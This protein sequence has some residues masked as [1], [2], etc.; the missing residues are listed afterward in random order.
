MYTHACRPLICLE[1]GVGSGAVL[2]AV[3]KA[4]G[5]GTWCIGTDI[6]HH[7]VQAVHAC[8]DINQMTGCT[9]IILTDLMSAVHHRLKHSIDLLIFNPPYVP[10]DEVPA[11]PG[12]SSS[13]SGGADGTEVT[14][15]FI[16]TIPDLLSDTGVF[17]LVLVQEND[18]ESIMQLMNTL[19][20]EAEVSLRRKCGRE[21][22][23]VIR[24]HRM[25]EYDHTC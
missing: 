25:R 1:V 24:G 12:I 16:R 2:L 7:V 18:P 6:N 3:R 5:R 14:M 15:R 10:T 4:L 20:L 22:L 19:S 21:Q 8:Q 13:W 17:Y 11:D 23:S 9:D